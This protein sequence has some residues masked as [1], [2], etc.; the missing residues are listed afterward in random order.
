MSDAKRDGPQPA[1][2]DE[3]PGRHGLRRRGH[4][5]KIKVPVGLEKALYHAARDDG[6]KARLLAEP[7]AAIEEVGISLRPSELAVLSA[8]PP[9]ALDAMI[10]GLVPENPRRRK[11]MG[12]VA[13]AAA[14]LAAGTVAASCGDDDDDNDTVD[15]DN[16]D[17]DL[18][19]GAGPD[20]DVDVDSDSDTDTVDTE[21][22]D[23]DLD[24]G[25][26]PDSG[27]DGGE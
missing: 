26:A 21:N 7:R 11:F 6:F 22:P 3:Q 18:D 16:Q 2:V 24:G 27:V 15:T 4:R 10:A 9:T 20:T 13:A 14:S 17:T 5:G 25:I 1:H 12:L 19:G 23:T 8:I